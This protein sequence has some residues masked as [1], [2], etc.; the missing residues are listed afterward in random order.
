MA[1]LRFARDPG[2]PVAVRLGSWQSDFM[3]H[4]CRLLIIL[5]VCVLSLSPAH[6]TC[7]GGGGGGMGGT[8]PSGMGEPRAYVVPWKVLQPG[9][10]PLNA[11]LIVYWF[12]ATKEEIKGHDLMASRALTLAS[13]QCVGMQ[14]FAPMDTATIAKWE[15]TEKLPAALLV[16]DG[17]VIA[18]VDG[19]NGKLRAGKVEDM[20]RNELR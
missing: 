18:R 12:P 6:A 3:R 15:L 16:S 13:A 19:E 8:M 17:A 5:A 1:A 7:G 20:V 9:E 11:P 10:A 2:F 14:L 4:L